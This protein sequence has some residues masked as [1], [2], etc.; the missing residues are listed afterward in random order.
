MWWNWQTERISLAANNPDEGLRA[1]LEAH[2]T[3]FP[4]FKKYSGPEIDI[5]LE[6]VTY[7]SEGESPQGLYLSAETVH[8]LS[9]L[10]AAF[11]NDVVVNLRVAEPS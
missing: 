2:T 5:Y 4:I 9:E 6:V 7:Y 1:F 3:I 11:D 8:L 10:R